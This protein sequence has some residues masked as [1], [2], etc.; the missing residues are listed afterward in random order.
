MKTVTERFLKYVSFDTMSDEF[1]ETCPSTDKQKALGAYLVEEMKAM[2]IADA[3]MDEF[4]YVYGTVPG[5]PRLPTIGLIAHMI[6][7]AGIVGLAQPDV[8]LLIQAHITAG[9]L[10]DLRLNI[11]TGSIGRGIHMGYQ[12]D[13][14][15]SGIT[16]YCA[17]NIAKFVHTGIFNAH[18]FH[19]LHQIS[20][21]RL[22]LVRGGTGFGIFI[23]LG[24][25]GNI[26][27]E[28]LL[29]IDHWDHPFFIFKISI[30]CEKEAAAIAAASI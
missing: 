8:L 28:A 30:R 17:V 18:G 29:Y 10:H 24:V 16:G 4:G 7:K 27:Q 20:A 5:D 1:S 19:F 21:Q 14:G 22:L 2:G 11:R 26:A 25:K 9:V 15:K 3:R 12:A 13:G 23:R 6:L